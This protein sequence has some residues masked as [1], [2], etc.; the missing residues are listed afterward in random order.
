MQ[1]QF[2]INAIEAEVKRT[3]GE[4]YE[5]LKKEFIENLDREKATTIASVS[6][7][8]MKMVDIQSINDRVILTIRTDFKS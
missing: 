6:L 4:K 2:I 3:I 7:H 8:L 1:D 5:V